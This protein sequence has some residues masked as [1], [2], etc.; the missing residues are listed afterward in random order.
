MFASL[1]AADD[2]IFNGKFNLADIFFLIAAILFGIAAVFAY[3]VKTFYA[4][5]ISAGLC[6]VALGWLVL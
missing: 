5:L 2:G 3:Q 6:L 1:L 4:T